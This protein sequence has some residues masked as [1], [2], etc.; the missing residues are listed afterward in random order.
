MQPFEKKFISNCEIYNWRMLN[1]MYHG[2]F[3]N[4]AYTLF[5]LLDSHGISCLD[6]IDGDYA[7][8]YIQKSNIKNANLKNESPNNDNVKKEDK[9]DN[10]FKN[11][12]IILAR[13]LFGVKPLWFFSNQHYFC[14][15]SENK[16]LDYKGTLLN[17]RE[18]LSFNIKKWTLKKKKRKFLTLAKKNKEEND[19]EK[20]VQKLLVLLENAFDKRTKD[21][22][23]GILFSGGVDSTLLAYLAKRFE[24]KCVLYVAGMKDSPDVLC[25]EKAAQ[26]LNLPLKK[27]IIQEEELVPAIKEIKRLIETFDYMKVS[28]AL[29]FYFACQEAKKDK[30]K[31]ILS[32][33]GSEELF[34]GYERHMHA[35]NV[36]KEC[37][38]GLETMYERDLYRDD[39]ITMSQNLELRV[40]FLDTELAAYALTISSKLKIQNEVKKYILRKTALSL[41]VPE[42]FAMRKK[43][44]AQY[45]SAV[46]KAIEKLSSQAKMRKKEFVEKI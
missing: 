37:L 34:A 3:R 1:E 42:E 31:I 13:D 26:I 24:K 15:A 43:S 29:P 10:T 30:M 20:A 4:D 7:L 14:F 17:P 35:K 18:I 22:M 25:A 40:P 12:E 46:D 39:V 27:R 38:L 32:G 28:V 41:G 19:E 44:A 21:G 33:L 5:R 36:N 9:I 45:G 11:D 6:E 16:A 8:A 23:F 2:G